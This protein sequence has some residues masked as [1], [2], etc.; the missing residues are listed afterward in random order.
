MDFRFEHYQH[1]KCF[2]YENT[3]GLLESA[4]EGFAVEEQI[5]LQK[6]EV[7]VEHLFNQVCFN[8]LHSHFS[9]TYIC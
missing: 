9:P 5:L 7:I 2:H 3:T 1:F 8:V 4:S 6:A